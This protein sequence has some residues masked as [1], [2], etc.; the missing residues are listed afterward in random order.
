MSD[1]VYGAGANVFFLCEFLF[2]VPCKIGTSQGRARVNHGDLGHRFGVRHARKIRYCF[3][4]VGFSLGRCR[5]RFF[6]RREGS[7]PLSLKPNSSELTST[8]FDLVL[9]REATVRSPADRSKS[10]PVP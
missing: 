6:P 10:L 1:A 4:S 7:L 9:R 8:N 2:D 5:C 3:L